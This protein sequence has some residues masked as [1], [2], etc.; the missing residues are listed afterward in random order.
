MAI[1][2]VSGSQTG[3]IDETALAHA[4]LDIPLV[5]PGAT[6]ADILDAITGRQFERASAIVVAEGGV[7][8]GLIKIEGLLAAERNKTAIDIMD[9]DPPVVRP[10]MDQEAVAWRMVRHGENT[11]AVVD[12]E[13]KFRG[14]IPAS[15]M[16]AVLLRE[17][18]EDLARIGGFSHD[19]EVAATALQENVRRRIRHRLPWLM[20]GL[21]GSLIATQIVDAFQGE[22]Q[23]TLALALFLPGIVYLADAVGTQTETLV[24]RGLSVGVPIRRAFRQEAVTGVLIGAGLGLAFFPFALWLS[25]DTAVAFTVALSLLAACSVATLLALS[26]PWMLKRRGIDPA[27]GSGPLATVVQ[28]IASVLMY[29][30]F[31]T[32]FVT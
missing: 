2:S 12:G 16:L 11:L 5:A 7:F 19:T 20:V 13:G 15:A 18:A 30:S 24:I 23:K 17:H 29:F 8:H 22:L 4:V 3:L 6:V 28:D 1:Q 31:A 9:P 25:G 21:A 32:W 14:L 27:F 26:L 10:G